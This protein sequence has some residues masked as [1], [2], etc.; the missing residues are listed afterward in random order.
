MG[1]LFVDAKLEGA[2]DAGVFWVPHGKHDGVVDQAGDLA[3]DAGNPD[4]VSLI[5]LGAEEVAGESDP[6]NGIGTTDGEG[7]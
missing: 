4:L 2:G 3:S 5:D 7:F 6:I 1:V